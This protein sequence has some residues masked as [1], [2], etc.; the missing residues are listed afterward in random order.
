MVGMRSARAVAAALAL[1][2]LAGTAEAGSIVIGLDELTSNPDHSKIQQ[3][4]TG[5]AFL[6]TLAGPP[7]VLDPTDFGEDSAGNLY[8]GSQDNS[9]I[10]KVTP[11]GTVSTFKSGL[12]ALLL[13]AVGPDDGVYFTRTAGGTTLERVNQDGTIDIVVSGITSPRAIAFAANG[14][15]YYSAENSKVYRFVAG[16]STLFANVGSTSTDVISDMAFDAAGNLLV[17]QEFLNTVKS[18]DAGGAVS[19]F[20]TA[21]LSR[22]SG[23]AVDDGGG[24][25]VAN[26]NNGTVRKFAADGTDLGNFVSGLTRPVP[27]GF[28]SAVAN[29]VAVPAPGALAS[30]LAGLGLIGLLRRR[31]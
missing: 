28:W 22:P 24:V 13:M 31:R 3:Y 11:G 12:G 9:R 14:D 19:T 16:V 7:T 5:G 30:L 10:I 1:S 21:G 8:I 18:I 15:L 26:F 6:A 29:V 20:T 2:L 25:Y 23:I 4:G 17:T 27:V